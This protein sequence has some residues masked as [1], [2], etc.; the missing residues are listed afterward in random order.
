LAFVAGIWTCGELV[1]QARSSR[2]Y[3][4]IEEVYRRYGFDLLRFLHGAHPHLNHQD[5]EDLLHQAILKAV[6]RLDQYDPERGSLR[7]WVLGILRNEVL[8]DLRRRKRRRSELHAEIEAEAKQPPVDAGVISAEELAAVDRA[9]DELSFA[10]REALLMVVRS[11]GCATK[12]QVAARL[13]ISP[14]SVAVYRQRARQHLRDALS[15]KSEG[16]ARGAPWSRT[17]KRIRT[18]V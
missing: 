7:C 18:R 6:V 9:L 1:S 14:A 4:T 12:E 10:E 17:R 8:Q 11:E 16:E 15:R 3:V 2:S 13:G 5:C